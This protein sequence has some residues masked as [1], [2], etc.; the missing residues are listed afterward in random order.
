MAQTLK[1]SMPR[2]DTRTLSIALPIATYSTGASL[3]FTL[4][5]LADVDAAT[6]DTTAVLQKT[7]TDAN[8]TSTT[9]TNKNYTLTL[10]PS[11]TNSITP[12]VYRAEIEFVNSG[13]TTVL[14]YPDPSLSTWLF[15]ITGDVTRRTA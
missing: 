2:G 15:T 5:P 3:F 4:K 14:T 7:L 1:Y 10:S 11:D 6:T 8:I 12:G 13:A 9:A